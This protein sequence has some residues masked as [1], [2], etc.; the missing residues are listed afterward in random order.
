[1]TRLTKTITLFAP[2]V[3]FACAP[4]GGGGQDNSGPSPDPD[5][6]VAAET[7]IFLALEAS[8]RMNGYATEDTKIVH[9]LG[10]CWP[11]AKWYHTG[12]HWWQGFWGCEVKIG[13]KKWDLVDKAVQK[14]LP[15]YKKYADFGMLTYPMDQGASHVC[16][17]HH[18]NHGNGWGWGW[19]WG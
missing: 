19:G 10:K 18:G 14:T 2:V 5:V 15:H 16:G 17:G 7:Q 11:H 4:H 6:C 13:Q 8:D 1:M 12:P 3:L 9:G